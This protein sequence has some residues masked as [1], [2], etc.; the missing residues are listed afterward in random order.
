[1]TI[2]CIPKNKRKLLRSFKKSILPLLKFYGKEEAANLQTFSQIWLSMKQKLKMK[3][4]LSKQFR[5]LVD[6]TI[7]LKY[8]NF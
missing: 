1:M 6:V 8:S 7:Q 2:L 4:F 3:L 5:N